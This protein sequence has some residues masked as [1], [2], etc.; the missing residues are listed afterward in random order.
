MI[1][2]LPQIQNLSA[3]PMALSADSSNESEDNNQLFSDLMT[4][5]SIQLNEDVVVSD[6]VLLPGKTAVEDVIATPD[7]AEATTVDAQQE[8]DDKAPEEALS[9]SVNPSLAWLDSAAFLQQNKPEM[10]EKPLGNADFLTSSFDNQQ[11]N[12]PSILTSN[13]MNTMDNLNQTPSSEDSGFDFNLIKMDLSEQS[14]ES[15][16]VSDELI[17]DLNTNPWVK[18]TDSLNQPPKIETTQQA[19]IPVDVDSAEWG[20]AFHEQVVFMSQN[21]I[22]RAVIKLHPEDLGPLEVTL[23][24]AN[25]SASMSIT[26]QNG[27]VKDLVE[28]ALPKLRDM[29][30]AQ[31]LDLGAVQ[32]DTHNDPSRQ[33]N[34]S[35]FAREDSDMGFVDN[36]P[37]EITTKKIVSQQGLV[38]YFA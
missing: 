14:S 12:T 11:K 36:S 21:N 37:I 31:G 38:D 6:E 29:M 25:D 19:A 26:T 13:T 34:P 7:E 18:S 4:D 1:D 16:E 22:Q 15:P 23:K 27:H 9:D 35:Y 28:Q 17:P 30:E 32:V 2:A 24:M 5:A 3:T 20:S 10:I 8:S 33:S